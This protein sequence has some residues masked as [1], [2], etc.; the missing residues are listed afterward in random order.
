MMA[1]LKRYAPVCR[2]YEGT[3]R[4]TLFASKPDSNLGT[5][6][7]A[8]GKQHVNHTN[9]CFCANAERLARSLQPCRQEN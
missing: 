5:A 1:M 6:A 3:G 4:V 8:S 7:A 2:V 9:I